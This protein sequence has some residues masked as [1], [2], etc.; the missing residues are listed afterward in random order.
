M[1]LEEVE[2]GGNG[3]VVGHGFGEGFHLPCVSQ[4]PDTDR[5][6]WP[7]RMLVV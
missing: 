1:L 3:R 7:Y 5:P 6:S 4:I 2:K